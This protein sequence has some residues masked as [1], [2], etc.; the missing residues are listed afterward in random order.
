LSD[1]VPIYLPQAP[2]DPFDGRPLRYRRLEPGF[3][4]YSVGPARTDDGGQRRQPV[5]GSKGGR[6]S[7]YTVFRVER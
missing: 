6:T 4:V 2:Q 1:L 5:K 3:V 7:A